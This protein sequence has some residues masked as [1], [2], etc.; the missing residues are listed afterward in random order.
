M[1]DS[2]RKAKA[3]ITS[4][5][6]PGTQVSGSI[7]FSGG[8][9]VNGV[10]MGNVTGN[11]SDDSTVLILGDDA[12]IE[13]DIRASQIVLSGTVTGDVHGDD[14]ELAPHAK[15]KGNIYYRS[16]EMAVGAEVNGQLIHSE[17]QAT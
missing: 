15:V 3:S 4:L 1:W 13:G 8:L 5:I 6:G 9:H 14:V 7:T 12:S 10:V 11:A 16:L 2:K 17:P